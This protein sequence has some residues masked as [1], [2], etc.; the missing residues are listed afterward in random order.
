MESLAKRITYNT[1]NATVILG[2]VL[3]SVCHAQVT[4]ESASFSNP[5]EA[6]PNPEQAAIGNS[7]MA[8]SIPLVDTR[9][10]SSKLPD[11]K[12]EAQ[13]DQLVTDNLKLEKSSAQ[14]RATTAAVADGV[15]TGL[16]LSLGAVESNPVI[17]ATPVGIVA[18]TG[19]KFAI[20][21]YADSMPE[22]QKR[23][24]LKTSSAVWGGA[25]VNNILV[26]LAAPPPMPLVA[27]V[28]MGIF[29]WRQM[30]DQYDE[31]DKIAASRNK[32]FQNPQGEAVAALA[33]G[34]N[35]SGE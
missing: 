35:S 30:N 4:T 13:I 27:G 14:K 10:I 8:A 17:G 19:M 20:L 3:A 25:A 32:E 22:E 28:L 5:Q 11:I 26:L 7:I 9:P 12:Q 31:E 16:A 33:D 29:T 15:T 34:A 2:M 18:T 1:K 24:T 23:F 21:K 6:K